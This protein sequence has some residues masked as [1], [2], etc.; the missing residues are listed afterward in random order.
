MNVDILLLPT[1]ATRVP[2]VHEAGAHGLALSPENTVFAN[3][4]G[5]PAISVRCGFDG[6]GLPLG[7]QI[8]G[9]PWG[10]ASVLSAGY[11]YEAAT[12]WAP[13]HAKV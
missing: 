6:N 9:K 8:V 11:R 7:L 5:L 1:T 2:S 3:Y 10:E 13:G 12:L 4:Y